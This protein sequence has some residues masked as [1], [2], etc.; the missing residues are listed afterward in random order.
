M[1]WIGEYA[2]A[3]VVLLGAV[4]AIIQVQASFGDGMLM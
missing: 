4:L 3:L 2:R 1:D